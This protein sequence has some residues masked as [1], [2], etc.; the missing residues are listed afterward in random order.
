MSWTKAV[1]DANSIIFSDGIV[2]FVMKQVPNSSF[3]IAETP[4]TQILWMAIEGNNPSEGSFRPFFP[5]DN[6]SYPMVKSF[7]EHLNNATSEN[8][9]LPTALEWEMAAKC[10]NDNYPY[11]YAG[12]DDFESIDTSRSEVKKNEPNEMGLYCMTGNIMEWTETI[13]KIPV[14]RFV[15]AAA[16]MGLMDKARVE[17]KEERI[18]KGGSS[19][20]GKYTSHIK[21]NNHYPADYRNGLC[22]FRLAMDNSS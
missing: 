16:S 14:D 8:F 9:R 11:M 18:L 3:M 15:S 5:I 17:Y 6:V 2:A 21:D 10:G 4:V 7:I 22:G 12:T 13:I 19:V 20:H 1:I